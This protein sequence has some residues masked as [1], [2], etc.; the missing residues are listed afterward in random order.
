MYIPEEYSLDIDVFV[1]KSITSNLPACLLEFE[2]LDV[3][4]E[5]FVKSKGR[6][7]TEWR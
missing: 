7:K 6:I 5:E 2:L 1:V 4:I 3:D